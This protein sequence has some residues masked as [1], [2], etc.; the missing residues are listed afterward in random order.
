LKSIKRY[1]RVKKEDI[2]YLTFILESYSGLAV[3][4]TI[5]S[6]EALI[7][8]LISP[9]NGDLFEDLIFHLDHKEKLK[10]ISVTIDNN[11]VNDLKNKSE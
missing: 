5:D 8:I 11:N 4:R 6:R 7:E 10:L 9:Q 2:G 1:F 3:I